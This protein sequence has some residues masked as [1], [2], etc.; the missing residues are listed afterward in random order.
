MSTYLYGVIRKPGPGSQLSAGA[1]GRGVGEPSSP[2]RLLPFNDVCGL[3]STVEDRQIGERGGVRAMRRDMA[4]HSAVLDRILRLRTVLPARFGILFPDD[5]AVIADFLKPQLRIL[6]EYLASLRG[7]VELSLRAEYEE[8]RI[9]QEVAPMLD[10]GR[11]A[12]G[13]QEKIELGRQIAALIEQQAQQEAKEIV[14]RLRQVA[15]D[16]AVSDTAANLLVLRAS[17]LVSRKDV[18]QFDRELARIARQARPR[19][20]LACLGPLPPYSFVDLRVGAGG[21]CTGAEAPI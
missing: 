4:A 13:Y 16:V 2:V 8:Q 20:K 10:C 18:S 6:K 17:F 9:L 3:V 15:E 5:H 14:D 1:S 21:R 11:P 12:L 7:T 19:M